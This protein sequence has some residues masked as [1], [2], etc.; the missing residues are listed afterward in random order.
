VSG[1]GSGCAGAPLSLQRPKQ[2]FGEMRAEA[3]LRH[4]GTLASQVTGTFLAWSF[5]AHRAAGSPNEYR[6]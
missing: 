1:S 4:E 6:D 3:E 5:E 2:S